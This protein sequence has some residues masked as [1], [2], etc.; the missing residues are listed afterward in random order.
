[1][2]LLTPEDPKE[3][4][5]LKHPITQI[6]PLS[7]QLQELNA[8]CRTKETPSNAPGLYMAHQIC[9]N[10]PQCD[11][12]Q[13]I[14]NGCRNTSKKAK[15]LSKKIRE[16]TDEQSKVNSDFGSNICNS[17]A[18]DE[19]TCDL[20][21]PHCIYDPKR[22]KCQQKDYNDAQKQ[23]L[24]PKLRREAELEELNRRLSTANPK[25]DVDISSIDSASKAV[26]DYRPPEQP[27]NIEAA[28]VYRGIL[29]DR[30]LSKFDFPLWAFTRAW[31]EPE[32]DPIPYKRYESLWKFANNLNWTHQRRE[33]PDKAA[34][35]LQAGTHLEQKRRQLQNMVHTMLLKSPD[36]REDK[37]HQSAL[38]AAFDDGLFWPYT[39]E[40]YI[41]I[42]LKRDLTHKY[43]LGPLLKNAEP[44]KRKFEAK[45]HKIPSEESHVLEWLLLGFFLKDVKSVHCDLWLDTSVFP[46]AIVLRDTRGSV[47][48]WSIG[49]VSK[50]AELVGRDDVRLG[51]RDVY[52]VMY[53]GLSEDDISQEQKRTVYPRMLSDEAYWLAQQSMHPRELPEDED[54]GGVSQKEV[55]RLS[56]LKRGSN[57]PD[58]SRL[59]RS[60]RKDSG[61]EG[62]SPAPA[63]EFPA[64]R[65]RKQSVRQDS[66]RTRRRRS[67][68]KDSGSEDESPAP[69]QEFP[70]QREGG[71]SG[72]SRVYP[73]PRPEL[74]AD[75]PGRR[76]KRSRGPVRD[77]SDDD[78][79]G[80]PMFRRPP[81]EQEPP[82]RRP[83]IGGY[84]SRLIA[85][86]PSRFNT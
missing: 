54:D 52:P 59:R 16:L 23:P 33:H 51:V 80:L 50:P 68:R 81:E 64:Q 65:Q 77:S 73:A 1:M 71:S 14:G 24:T 82:S 25:A 38:E 36:R 21:Q 53:A 42:F 28:S 70:A 29:N 12:G 35:P 26:A 56:S 13:P 3:T 86:L 20:L 85:G 7:K 6:G 11:G 9:K 84:S 83:K 78:D 62:E 61:S 19:S 17:H 39:R 63:Q 43:Q 55:H 27:P 47:K 45:K 32:L 37:Q 69:V 67:V 79:D 76:Q 72:S 40:D 46:A 48:D 2:G 60:V 75:A 58:A 10:Q 44:Y 41:R 5:H 4:S 31:M 22:Q 49:D 15:K 57:A 30:P 18:F 66:G 74:M 8:Q 34:P